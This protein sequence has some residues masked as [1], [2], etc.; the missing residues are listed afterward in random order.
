MPRRR[1][2]I[3]DYVSSVL[4]SFGYEAKPLLF[5]LKPT[6]IKTAQNRGGNIIIPSEHLHQLRQIQGNSH[7]SGREV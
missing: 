3:S 6:F 1:D 4:N 5:I 2:F 7:L